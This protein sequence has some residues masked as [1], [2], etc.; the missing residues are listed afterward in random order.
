M[1]TADWLIF[2][3]VMAAIAALA[4][5]TSVVGPARRVAPPLR[6][7]L[8]VALTLRLAVMAIAFQRT[9]FDIAIWFRQTAEAV[10]QHQDPLLVLPRYEWNFLPAMPYVYALELSIGLPWEI[11]AKLCPVAADLVTTVLVGSLAAPERAARVRWQ[12]AVHP[13]PLLVVAWHGQIDPIGVAL[14]LTALWAARRAKPGASGLLLGLA[15]SVKTWPVLFA[16]GVLRETPRR[17][18]P[19]VA[20]TA[21]LPPLL[22]LASMPLLLN[23]DMGRS[24]QVLGS[25]RG[26]TGI[27]GWT[28][29]QRLAGNAGQGFGGP[30]VDAY[31]R[32][33]LIAVLVAL[34]LV[35]LAFW[36]RLDG[37][38]LTAALILAFLVV[39]AGFGLQYLLWPAALLMIGGGW[40]A[41]VYLT[42]A[43]GYAVFYYLVFF[44][45]PTVGT[46]QMVVYGSV[47]VVAAALLALPWERLRPRLPEPRRDSPPPL[48]LLGR[49]R[50]RL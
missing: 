36:S 31:Q 20:A 42:V 3:A 49:E 9:P 33:G 37:V 2:L 14:G 25:Y 30:G 48:A 26:N 17:R 10:L 5:L 22:L 40:R 23:S 28:G 12:Y 32:L 8:A 7:T 16:P 27:W 38:E 15:A 34:G 29:L 1:G 24:L 18:W 4:L 13:L 50:G 47:P 44:P 43:A 11:A 6:V 39:T 35:V 19:V 45:A 21:V 46:N 41:W